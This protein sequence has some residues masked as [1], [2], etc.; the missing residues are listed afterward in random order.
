MRG[1]CDERFSSIERV[2]EN[3]S[4]GWDGSEKGSVMEE[5]DKTEDQY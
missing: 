3:E 4:E 2:L 1:L 5:E